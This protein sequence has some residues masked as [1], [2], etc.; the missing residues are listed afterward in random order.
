VC[1]MVGTSLCLQPRLFQWEMIGVISRW[2]PPKRHSV[3]LVVKE[4]KDGGGAGEGHRA[5][6]Q[7]DQLPLHIDAS[8]QHTLACHDP[9]TEVWWRSNFEYQS[10]PG[11]TYWRRLEWRWYLRLHQHW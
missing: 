3:V 4:G 10:V 6:R 7:S 5:Q 9:E 2:T 8:L 1:G 11:K